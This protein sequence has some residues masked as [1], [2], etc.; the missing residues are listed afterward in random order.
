MLLTLLPLAGWAAEIDVTVAPYDGQAVWCGG[1]PTVKKNWVIVSAAVAVPADV[2]AA[3]AEKLVAQTLDGKYGV[4]DHTYK[5]A[6]KD[7]D[8]AT[9]TSGGDDYVIHTSGTNTAIL[10]IAKSTV[11]PEGIE[12][13]SLEYVDDPLTYN[14]SA[15]ALLKGGATAT[16]TNLVNVPVIYTLTTLPT[17]NPNEAET[18]DTFDS[19]ENVKGTNA[20]EYT[21]WYKVA[22]TDDYAGTNWIS[23]SGHKTIAKAELDWSDQN[24]TPT[25]GSWT[26][27]GEAHARAIAPVNPYTYATY[28]YALTNSDNDDDWSTEIPTG[29]N[30]NENIVWWRVLESDN[31]VPKAPAQLTA[32]FTKGTPEFTTLP[33]FAESR[34]Y[35]GEELHQ[36]VSVGETTLGAQPVFRRR[37]KNGNGNWGAWSDWKSDLDYF[38]RTAAGECQLQYTTR[39]TN[40]LKPAIAGPSYG[41][42]V[43]VVISKADITTEQFTAPTAAA[44]TYDG[45][46]QPL[47]VEGAATTEIPGTFTYATSDD[48]G[49]TWSDFGAV[50]TGKDAKSYYVKYKFTPTANYNTYEAVVENVAI[51][52][53]S[54]VDGEGNLAAGFALSAADMTNANASVYTGT[55]KTPVVV[56]RYNDAAMTHSVLEGGD[57]ARSYNNN[58]NAS[59]EA[60]IIFTAKNNFKGAYTQKFTINKADIANLNVT[61]AQDTYDYSAAANEPAVTTVKLGEYTF[62]A[63]DYAVEYTNNTNAGTATVTVTPNVEN[64]TAAS[65]SVDFTINKAPLTVKVA[66]AEKA[67]GSVDPTPAVESIEGFVGEETAAVL[68]ESAYSINRAAGADPAT[69]AYDVVDN[70]LANCNYSFVNANPQGALT[71]KAATV[72][73]R[74]TAVNGTYGDYTVPTLDKSG[75]EFTAEGLKA[76]HTIN[77][78]TFTVTNKQGEEQ[79]VG[80]MLPAGT[81]TITP[82]NAGTD[83]GSYTFDYQTATLTI[84]KRDLTLTAVDQ[85]IEYGGSANTDVAFEGLDKT[86]DVVNRVG[87]DELGTITIN[88]AAE[89]TSIDTHEGAITLSVEN[90]N[91]NYNYTLVDGNLK[92]TAPVAGITLGAGGND[93]QTISD[94][95]DQNVK[96]T[97][98]FS[99]RNGRTLGETRNWEAN[100]W[101]TLVLPF[102]I[103]VAD[104][105][106]AL[107]YAI[108]NV[109]DPTRTEVSGT[110]SKFYGKLTMKGGNGKD[111]V[112]AANKPFMVKTADDISG[113]ID[114]G[115]QTIVAPTNLTVD[116]GANVEF[117]GTYTGKSV[118]KDDDAAIWFLMGNYTN[119]AFIKSTSTATW[120]I[121]P[122]EGFIDMSNLPANAREITFFMEEEDGTVTAIKSV[123][124]EDAESAESAAEGWYT[125]NGIKL[126]AKPTQKGIYIFN[127]KKVAI[128]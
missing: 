7:F 68:P 5:L 59:N 86:V 48:K 79:A 75:F 15:Q 46:E 101:N 40:N 66:D 77:A 93:F 17:A 8:D 51:A 85:T 99:A 3:I 24:V 57:Y 23:M 92:I 4:G 69:Y 55:A 12:S 113:V 83:A 43:D 13:G 104:L 38:T 1:A 107:G 50:P 115:T 34:P 90:E 26:Y 89:A 118:D 111:D 58:I 78:L 128:Q 44:L 62:A 2:K 73:V 65:K 109:I 60:E 74:A 49:E 35:N 56:L 27:D 100:Y 112:L 25:A 80:T 124:A 37:T 97:I 53:L 39:T 121:L 72:I 29:T 102:D 19:Y 67:Y 22:D 10:T 106:K 16:T 122:F 11:V 120:N 88:V 114:F 87:D 28:Q 9:V 20:G 105:S 52:P 70:D 110:G 103:T 94:Y 123:D 76:G 91:A 45:T 117:T 127:G 14:T 21:V 36:I 119:W 116:A 96:V 98:D 95:A 61:L 54:I 84:A 125:I 108:V 31:Y 6:L 82:S 47:V 30:Y 32:T 41:D 33:A 18:V 126:N 71:I 42:P 64:F 81:Y 63:E